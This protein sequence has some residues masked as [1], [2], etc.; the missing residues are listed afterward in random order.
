MPNGG[1][2]A[3]GTQSGAESPKISSSNVSA[4]DSAMS[5]GSIGVADCMNPEVLKTTK[6]WRF[7]KLSKAEL[8]GLVE[9]YTQVSPATSATKGQMIKILMDHA[10]SNAQ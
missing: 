7:Q 2:S 9:H 1:S 6:L 10:A 8:T 3:A 5:A 4:P